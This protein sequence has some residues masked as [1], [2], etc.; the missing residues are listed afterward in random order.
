MASYRVTCITKPHPSSSHE[1]M[2][3]IGYHESHI[4]PKVIITVAEA[5]RRIDL[6]PLEFY[7]SSG[8][9]TAHVEVVRPI[10]RNPYIKPFL[11][12]LREIICY[13]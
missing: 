13:R 7:V 10:G 9:A 11:I 2:T 12:T 6:N 8:Q 4:R 1:H 3:H 5:I